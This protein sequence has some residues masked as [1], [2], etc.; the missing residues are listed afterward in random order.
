[1]I[2][3]VLPFE[4]KQGRRTE[5]EKVFQQVAVG[6]GR[7]ARI[8][9]VE[10]LVPNAEA[11]AAIKNAGKLVGSYAESLNRLATSGQVGL[12]DLTKITDA[13]FSSIAK[14]APDASM[15]I[16]I[17]F[18]TVIRCTFF[19]MYAIGMLHSI[20]PKSPNLNVM[21]TPTNSR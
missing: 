18:T 13:M 4:L 1:M 16:R 7:S 9:I 3:S 8:K 15:Q 11:K 2:L 20:S 19:C 5:F 10:R 21:L 14:S 12:E 17:L 6:E